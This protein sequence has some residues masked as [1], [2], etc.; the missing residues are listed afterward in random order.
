DALNQF[1][2]RHLVE[3]MN[4]RALKSHGMAGLQ[5]WRPTLA[6][7]RV[8]HIHITRKR[9]YSADAT[10]AP[11]HSI[12]PM[13]SLLKTEAWRWK[14]LFYAYLMVHQHTINF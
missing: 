12:Y 7:A 2:D 8:G 1:T 6:A 11:Q 5:E 13:T 10:T 3:A 14:R 4:K 9:L